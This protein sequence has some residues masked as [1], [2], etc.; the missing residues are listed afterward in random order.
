M[1]QVFRASGGND[2]VVAGRQFYRFAI[3]PVDLRL[4]VKVGRQAFRWIRIQAISTIPDCERSN[5]R[6][7]VF[8]KD[9]EFDLTRRL[10]IEQD[11][12]LISESQILAALAD[13]KG[14]GGRTLAGIATVDFDDLVIQKE[15]RESFFHG[16][17][18][19]ERNLCPAI[20]HVGLGQH[21]G[22]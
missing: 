21:H 10:G 6:L 16:R 14:D 2:G 8:I 9:V 19:R 4:K 13:A 3:R 5:G 17:S 12:D 11:T 15:A 20:P 18:G 22:R 1:R 7:S